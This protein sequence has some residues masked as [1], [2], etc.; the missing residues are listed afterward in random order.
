MCL[1]DLLEL[2]RRPL[3]DAQLITLLPSRFAPHVLENRGE[4]QGSAV[5]GSC[6]ARGITEFAR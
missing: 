3:P 1:S 5:C 6:H 4:R 2:G